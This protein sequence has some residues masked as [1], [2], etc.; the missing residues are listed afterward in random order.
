MKKISRI[1]LILL[2]AVLMLS[3]AACNR[4][5]D[6]GNDKVPGTDGALFDANTT[7]TMIVPSHSSW[8]FDKD[9]KVWQYAREGTG[10]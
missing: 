7:I 4:P 1:T 3:L 6:N 9:W 5:G 10:A 2:A 8:P